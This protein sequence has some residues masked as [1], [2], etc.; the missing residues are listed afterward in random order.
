MS[1]TIRTAVP[2]DAEALLSIYVHYVEN[3]AVSQEYTVPSVAEFQSRIENTLRHYP[4]LIA[5][6]DG[7][8]VGYAYAAPFRPREG[9]AKSCEVSIYVDKDA[10]GG[11]V[12]RRLYEHLETHLSDMGIET[13]Y[14]C[15]VIPRGEDAYLDMNSRDF[16]LHMG[17]TVAGHF[18]ACTT[19]FGNVYDVLGH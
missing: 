3:T 7:K 5:E 18:H 4:Y 10:H 13:G 16:H 19:K 6:R 14:V 12:G 11:G 9:Y 17:Y 15:I 1:I 8:A 2:E